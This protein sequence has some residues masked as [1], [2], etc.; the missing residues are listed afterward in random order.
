MQLAFVM[1]AVPRGKRK[2]KAKQ[3]NQGLGP[4]V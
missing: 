1:A 3:E 4:R 2:G